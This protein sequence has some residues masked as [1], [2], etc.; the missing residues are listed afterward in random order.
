MFNGFTATATLDGLAVVL[1][2]MLVDDFL[3]MTLLV[4]IRRKI[5]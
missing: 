4:S 5:N 1:V 2:L 3:G